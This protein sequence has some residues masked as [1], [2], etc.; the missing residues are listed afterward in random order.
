M[1]LK[2]EY[3][4]QESRFEVNF[5]YMV[6]ELCQAYGT[7]ALSPCQSSR[8]LWDAGVLELQKHEVPEFSGFGGRRL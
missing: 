6:L 1:I 3:S 7:I 2:P 5:G 4:N 8:V